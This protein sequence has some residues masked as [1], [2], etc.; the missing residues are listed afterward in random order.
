MFLY[1]RKNRGRDVFL[2][3]MVEQDKSIFQPESPTSSIG[4]NI[5]DGSLLIDQLQRMYMTEERFFR[6]DSLAT[7]LIKGYIDKIYW[8]KSLLHF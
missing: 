2:L 8:Q 7:Y 1:D 3:D 5:D 6:F 4:Q